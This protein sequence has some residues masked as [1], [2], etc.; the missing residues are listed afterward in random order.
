MAYD[1]QWLDENRR[2]FTIKAY[3]P[4]T[5]SEAQE[6]IGKLRDIADAPA[7][8]FMI[9]DLTQFDVMKAVSSLGKMLQRE[10][11]PSQTTALESSR[12]AV[13]GGGP[14]VSMGLQLVQGMTPLDLI[15]A[16]NDEA[17]ARQWLDDEARLAGV[18]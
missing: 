11:V 18:V 9:V 3:D 8:F 15:R 12:V 6:L 10:S 14:M 2:I 4:M 1:F 13:V 7:P 5:E 17:S 16:F